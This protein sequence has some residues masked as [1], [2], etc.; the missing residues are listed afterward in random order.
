MSM[1][2]SML[3][4]VMLIMAVSAAAFFVPVFF[5]FNIILVLFHIVLLES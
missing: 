4:V 5:L 2:I 1:F 3:A